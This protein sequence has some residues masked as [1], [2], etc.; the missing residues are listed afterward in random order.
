MR[1]DICCLLLDRR[2]PFVVWDGEMFRMRFSNVLSA[3]RHAVRCRAT[4]LRPIQSFDGHAVQAGE[5][6]GGAVEQRVALAYDSLLA[7]HGYSRHQTLS[8]RYK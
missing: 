3:F 5:S 1:T 8:N 6:G 7:I 2:F 4:W